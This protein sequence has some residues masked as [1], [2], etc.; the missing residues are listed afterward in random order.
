MSYH[1]R[2][3]ALAHTEQVDT[4]A[5]A[6]CMY[7]GRNFQQGKLPAFFH[8]HSIVHRHT[9]CFFSRAEHAL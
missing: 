6:D 5:K 7:L 3:S 9:E 4:K 8:S 1:V 2:S